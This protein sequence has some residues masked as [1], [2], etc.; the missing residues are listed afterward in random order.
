MNPCVG[1]RQS[2][3]ESETKLRAMRDLFD[4]KSIDNIDG[5]NM[6]V[7]S[8]LVESYG[9][10][11]TSFGDKMFKEIVWKALNCS[12]LFFFAGNRFLSLRNPFGSA[13]PTQHWP[14]K[15][16]PRVLRL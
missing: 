10:S 16:R 13:R 5:K 15:K 6:K 1:R 9:T 11:D 4:G 12:S 7:D 2:E 3:I 8:A 14:G